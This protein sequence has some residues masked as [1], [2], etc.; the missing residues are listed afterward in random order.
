[1]GVSVGLSP[2]GLAWYPSLPNI[3][4]APGQMRVPLQAI[5]G[6]GLAL[7]VFGVVVSTV[8]MVVRY[9]RSADVQRAQMR[10]I[11]GAVV[12]FAGAGL[13]FIIVRYG[14]DLPYS[15]GAILLAH[16]SRG[17]L[18][19]AGRSRDRDPSAPPV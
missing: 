2:T 18:S 17:R 19:P 7:M 6:L 5:A 16:G 10:W 9:R 15:S 3:F 1:M 13:P 14:L 4:A 12:L 8:S 11:A